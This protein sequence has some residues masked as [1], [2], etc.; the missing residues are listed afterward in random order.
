[1]AGK[2]QLAAVCGTS[3]VMA[4]DS[5]WVENKCHGEKDRLCGCRWYFTAPPP[6]AEE[7]SSDSRQGGK[8]KEVKVRCLP[9][10]FSMSYSFT[11]LC[12]KRTVVSGSDYT[13]ILNC[14]SEK[15]QIVVPRDRVHQKKL[16][17]ADEDHLENHLQPWEKN[18]FIMLQTEWILQCFSSY[19]VNSFNSII[20][21]YHSNI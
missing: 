17:V 20:Y 3:K 4:T 14:L 12:A 16:S 11:L 8:E 2:N 15:T 7:P 19:P 5:Q 6:E 18:K 21:S 10:F 9:S 1:M 13:H